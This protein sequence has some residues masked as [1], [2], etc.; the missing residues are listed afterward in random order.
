[1]ATRGIVCAAVRIRPQAA[2]VIVEGTYGMDLF[3]VQRTKM[4]VVR[5]VNFRGTIAQALATCHSKLI[6]S[7]KQLVWIPAFRVNTHHPLAFRWL[8]AHN[9]AYE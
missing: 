4:F 1:M 5:R 2:G 9:A 8:I 6:D 3:A 7:R